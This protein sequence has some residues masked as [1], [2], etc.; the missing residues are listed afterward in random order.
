MN[1]TATSTLLAEQVDDSLS[2]SRVLGSIT[3]NSSVK[4]INSLISKTYKQASTLFLTRR[5]LEALETLEPLINPLA[6]TDGSQTGDVSNATA[7]IAS[8][9]QSLRVKVWNL[10]LTLLNAIIELGADEGKNTFG[11]KEWRA[12]VAKARDGTIW[13]EV[14]NI[15]YGGTEG[16][17]DADVVSNLATLLLT[18]SPSQTLTQ[19]HL[20][21]YLSSTRHPTLDLSDRFRESSEQSIEFTSRPSHTHGTD[22]PRDL[23]S[24]IKILELYSLHVLPRNEEW[25]YARDFITMSEVLDDEHREA[26]LQALQSL[27]EQKDVDEHQEIETLRQQEEVRTRERLEREIRE[28]EER[29]VEAERGRQEADPKQHKRSDSEKDYGIDNAAST[30][31]VKKLPGASNLK[32]TRQSQPNNRLSPSSRA[33]APARKP[34][35]TSTYRRGV[36]LLAALQ[37]LVLNMAHSMSK[38]PMVLLRT[39]FFIIAFLVV[40]GRRDVRDRIGRIT[41]LGWDRIKGTIGMG[42]KVSYL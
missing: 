5:L 18:H 13:D 2:S 9:N 19:N 29:R 26:F 10:Y 39:I 4:R 17:V 16:N 38:N 8:A 23:K 1:G 40:L 3:S 6:N 36:A 20:E 37:K 15:G 25:Q 21:T 28:E 7:L 42:V 11:H 22:T 41:G 33:H 34:G 32:S 35:S 27:E 14:V 30:K 24:R 31:P 12:L